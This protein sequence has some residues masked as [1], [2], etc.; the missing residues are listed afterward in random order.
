MI[1]KALFSIPTAAALLFS[2]VLHSVARLTLRGASVL[3]PASW[4]LK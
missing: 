4:A 2:K 3:R 1:G